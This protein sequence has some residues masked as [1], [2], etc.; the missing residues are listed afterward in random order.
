M[1]LYN[2]QLF[3]FHL[4]LR[5]SHA[6]PLCQSK[7]VDRNLV[8]VKTTSQVAVYSSAD[9]TAERKADKLRYQAAALK[10]IS[11]VRRAGDFCKICVKLD[12][13]ILITGGSVRIFLPCPRIKTILP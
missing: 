3:I 9:D 7:I 6:V 10:L 4:D 13:M 11:G 2:P 12:G 5:C 8:A 1:L